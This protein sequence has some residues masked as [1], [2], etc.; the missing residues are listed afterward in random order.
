MGRKQLRLL[1]EPPFHIQRK[2]MF[3]KVCLSVGTLLL[4]SALHA[5]TL[6]PTLKANT[7]VVYNSNMGLVHEERSV[8]LNKGKQTLHY[9]DVASTVETDSVNV[10]FPSGV[11]LYSQKY[12]Y[13][14][15]TP[16][17]LLLAHIDKEVEVKVYDSKEKFELKRATLL[18]A[19]GRVLLRLEDDKI[20]QASTEDIVFN[21]IPATL[22]T[23]P[24][25]LWNISSSKQV[26]GTLGLDYII[27]NIHWKSDYVLKVDKDSANLS[28]LITLTNNSGKAFEDVSLKVLAGDVSRE[29]AKKVQREQ[30]YAAKAVRFDESDAVREVSHEG[31]HLYT[32]P[33]RVDLADKEKTQIKFIDETGIHILRRYDVHLNSPAWLNAEQKHK[34]N[35]YIEFKDLS[36]ALPQGTVR[37]YSTVEGSTV[38]LGINAIE[39]T[40]K[41]EKV[42]LQVGKNFDLLVKEVNL[43]RSETKKHYESTIKYRVTT[44]SD[45][46][47]KVELLV[48]F[49][50]ISELESIVKTDMKYEYRDGNTLK[51][52]VDV[53]A[54][55]VEEFIV[56]YRNKR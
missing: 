44:R 22:I 28:G 12:K 17:K 29:Y 9:P 19:E 6:S 53:K 27:N 15:I 18:S 32:I 47:K 21:S 23:K 52:L 50:R 39:H 25:L 46:D 2:A 31:Y 54:D 24:S 49:R 36:K 14:K 13:D 11:K 30:M 8:A 20:I 34:V 35:Q 4:Y 38:L 16:Q 56:K 26:E 51:F 1:F 41:K 33:F 5:A 37:T 40:P 3:K 48:P 45:G 10:V 7:L 43:Q 42:S 55:S